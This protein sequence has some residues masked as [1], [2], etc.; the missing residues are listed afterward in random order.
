[1]NIFDPEAYKQ[2]QEK[3]KERPMLLR[4]GEPFSLLLEFYDYGGRLNIASNHLHKMLQLSFQEQF[5]DQVLTFRETVRYVHWLAYFDY[6]D[7]KI[8]EKLLVYFGENTDKLDLD[9]SVSILFYLSVNMIRDKELLGECS[10]HLSPAPSA[11]SPEQL[12]VLPYIFEVQTLE[13][14][15]SFQEIPE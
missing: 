13:N 14:G 3:Q 10:R 9:S 7:Q 11:Y 1:M 5:R 8:S 2:F 4:A 6:G 15:F 12:S